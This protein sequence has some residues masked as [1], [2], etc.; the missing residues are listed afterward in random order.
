MEYVEAEKNN[1]SEME[2]ELKAAIG[3]T[4]SER[5]KFILWSMATNSIANSNLEKAKHY[6]DPSGALGRSKSSRVVRQKLVGKV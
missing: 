2:R 5:E 1:H 4:L 6:T 3:R